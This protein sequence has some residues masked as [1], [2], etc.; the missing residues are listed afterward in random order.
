MK[1]LILHKGRE[2]GLFNG[3]P[4]V[5]KSA[6]ASANDVVLGELVG[7]WS[8]EN[9]FLGYGFFSP[10]TQVVCRIFEQLR[11]VDDLIT[12]DFWWAR[13]AEAVFRRS[14]ES[15]EN[16][17]EKSSVGAYRLINSE[18]DGF[19]ALTVDVYEEENQDVLSVGL[20]APGAENL[21][22]LIQPKLI[23]LGYQQHF[24][25][26]IHEECEMDGFRSGSCLLGFKTHWTPE[27]ENLEAS[28]YLDIVN[29]QL[30]EFKENDEDL[31]YQ[32]F[33]EKSFLSVDGKSTGKHPSVVLR[34]EKGG[35]L[36][37]IAL[38]PPPIAFNNRTKLDAFKRY[39]DFNLQAI[40]CLV[41][42]GTLFTLTCSPVMSVEDLKEVLLSC[43][44]DL[45]RP[46]ILRSI[47]DTPIDFPVL[48]SHA[49]GQV[50]KAL[51][52]ELG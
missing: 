29:S 39:K 19:P 3:H 14:S 22:K 48:L 49:E 5:F 32:V 4:W 18:G 13:L 9:I 34:N 21:Y 17:F 47:Q 28:R 23:E 16:A 31:T 42:G 33:D 11:L 24:L 7:V 15:F 45:G 1:K 40:R 51:V 43:A 2:K 52:I 12:P 26:Y 35:S 30:N 50:Y 36:D 37:F 25:A 41:S 10:N 44:R 8:F 46:I 6:M 27:V 38:L 20:M